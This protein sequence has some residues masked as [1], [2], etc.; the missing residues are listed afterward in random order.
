M[1]CDLHFLHFPD[2]RLPGMCAMIPR[3]EAAES[4]VPFG[5][6]LLCVWRFLSVGVVATVAN[7]SAHRFLTQTKTGQS[8]AAGYRTTYSLAVLTLFGKFMNSLRRGK[9]VLLNFFALSGKRPKAILR[10]LIHCH[11][12]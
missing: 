3:H 11:H 12:R 10:V 6:C 2:P 9:G 7:R 8:H 5:C 1:L 4:A